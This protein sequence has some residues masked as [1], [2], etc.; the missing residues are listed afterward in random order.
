MI[1][2]HQL[3]LRLGQVE[4]DTIG[5]CVRGDKVDEES[6]NLPLEN[7][8]TGDESPESSPLGIHDRAKT[9]TSGHDENAHQGQPQRNFVAHHLRAGAQPT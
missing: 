1:S 4:R 6:N 3:G 2:R 7:V 9:K 8:P 5:F